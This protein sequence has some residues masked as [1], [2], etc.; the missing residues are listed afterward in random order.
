[1]AGKT[2]QD[3]FAKDM[4]WRDG[5]AE[6]IKY[7]RFPLNPDKNDAPVII[8]TKFAPGAVVAPHTHDCSY[9]EYVIEGEQTVGKVTFA[10]G[11]VRM[12]KGGFGYG[13]ITMGKDGCTVLIVFEDGSR[14]TWE[15]LPRKKQ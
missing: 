8:M 4:E 15:A 11:D 10:A 3:I 5:S 6:G 13:P 7:T 1:M 12:V 2:H 9:F 14:S